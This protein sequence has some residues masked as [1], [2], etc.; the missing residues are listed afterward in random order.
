MGCD[1]CGPSELYNESADCNHSVS[2]NGL[3]TTLCNQCLKE[4][5]KFAS[6]IT[7]LDQID[8]LEFKLSF[9]KST[10]SD[11]S[12]AETLDTMLELYDE[13]VAKEK[14]VFDITRKWLDEPSF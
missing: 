7:E 1:K 5:Q 11:K 2:L 10:I 12:T 9:W 3:Q 14:I 13:I 6:T 4:W 8:R